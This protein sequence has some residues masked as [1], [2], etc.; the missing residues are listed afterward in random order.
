M[1]NVDLKQ[2]NKFKPELLA[3]AGSLEKAITAF[4]YGADAVYL[5]TPNLSLRNKAQIDD[6]D[7]EKIVQY[8]H[9]I[10]KKVFVAINIFARDELYEEIKEQA[11]FLESINVDAIIAADPGIIEVIKEY[12]P[13]I[14]I[15]I[16]TQAN[17]ISYHTANFW[18]KNGASRIILGRELSKYDL[19]EIM[20]NKEKDLEIE[21]FIH[22]SFM[23][24]IFWKM[25]LKSIYGR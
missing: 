21:I 5:G 12:A 20:R 1:I 3:P 19:K 13:N 17:T 22:R 9:S 8:A 10:G 4:R 7:I 2:D 15:H 6:I 14:P 23:C 25:F 18:H 24:S 11:K 16:S